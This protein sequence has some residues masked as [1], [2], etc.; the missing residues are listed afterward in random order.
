[1]REK[2]GVPRCNIKKSWESLMAILT[3][4]KARADRKKNLEEGIIEIGFRG[5]F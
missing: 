3:L 2:K 1:V 5:N 4:K